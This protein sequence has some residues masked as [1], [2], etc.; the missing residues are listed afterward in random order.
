MRRL[1]QTQARGVA[2]RAQHLDRVSP[3]ATR[4]DVAA[5]VKKMG[6]L[7]IDTVNI[8]A[9]AH[10]MPLYSRLGPY[11]T[12]FL[13]DAASKPPRL[14]VEQ[15]GHEACFVPPT[16]HRVLAGFRRRWSSGTA[17][18]Q[19]PGVA[20][21]SERIV[22]HLRKTTATAQQ[23]NAWLLTQDLSDPE[24]DLIG[25][26]TDFE[27]SRNAVKVI[28]ENLFDADIIASAGRTHHFHRIYGARERVL[29]KTVAQILPPDRAE[30]IRA[31]TEISLDKVGIGSPAAFSDFFRLPLREVRLILAD[32]VASGRAVPV[33]V[34]GLKDGLMST[35]ISVPR[36][37]TGTTFLS[38]FDPLVFERNRAEALFGL[39][40]RIG[41]YTPAQK[42]TR[43]YYSLP[44]LHDGTIPARADLA[45][46]R[47]TGTLMVKGA[48]YEQGYENSETD[49]ALAGEL[50]RLASW[51][52]ASQIS[53]ADDAP[54]D[55]VSTVASLL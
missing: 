23:V 31:L 53:V 24:A 27:W 42:R 39:D 1:T 21:L 19:H 30:A 22:E 29:P 15:W 13:D 25:L 43:G 7:Q 16:T 38:P 2:I 34:P 46:D 26:K 49:R 44:L 12:G 48:W 41:I 8:L 3:S 28:L 55:A 35:A 37:V 52:D 50:A 14:I 11:D 51:L 54:G 45:L 6:V 18:E 10:Y 5:M 9:R 32:L 17:I 47:Q 4:A 36:Q 33:D 20:P 40:Y